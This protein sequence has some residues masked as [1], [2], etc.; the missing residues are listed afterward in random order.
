MVGW[1]L[2]PT[3][4]PAPRVVPRRSH[5]LAT[6]VWT[7]VVPLA[8]LAVAV[9]LALSW[10]HELPN[11]VASH[12]GAAGP[13]G[14]SSLD[15]TLTV[16]VVTVPVLTLTL[17]LVGL[18]AGRTSMVRRWVAFMAVWFAVFICA[19]IVGSL[20]VQRGLADAHEAPGLGVVIAVA[21]AGAVLLGSLAA[22]A[23]PADAPLPATGPVPPDA[24]RARSAG[25]AGASW[26]G[27]VAFTRPWLAAAVGAAIVAAI[28]LLTRSV[29]LTLPIAA[30]LGLTGLTL[31]PWTV[32]VDERGLTVRT[33]VPRPRT[34]VPLDEVESAEV[35]HVDPIRD[36]GGWGYR[37]GRSGRTGIVLRPGEAILVHRS[38]GR[39]LVVTVDD[40][41][42]GAAL[43]N[44]LAE[45]SRSGPHRR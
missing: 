35:V 33:L 2:V 32:T 45:R 41:H 34:V 39:E 38:G 27:I 16:M 42:R 7:L 5:R 11:P 9:G 4:T 13:D 28:A 3:S 44:T 18:L 23:T 12:W 1:G 37:V 17:W 15:G 10:R 19:L 30:V 8:V 40:A 22:A 21:L 31:G 6:T 43:L 29:G 25:T 20:A 26:T 36:F 24:P 14:F